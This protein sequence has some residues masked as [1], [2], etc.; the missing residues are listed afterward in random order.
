MN[1]DFLEGIGL[2]LEPTGAIF[3]PYSAENDTHLIALGE[4]QDLSITNKKT[5]ERH[6]VNIV[7]QLLDN[8][9]FK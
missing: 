2:K 8:S 9:D 5:K 1:K 4:W 6:S 7:M 3:T